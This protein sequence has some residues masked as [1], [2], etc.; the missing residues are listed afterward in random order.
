MC[1]RY[2]V[3]RAAPQPLRAVQQ[4][5]NSIDR[6]ARARLARRL[7]R[8]ARPGRRARARPSAARG[9]PLARAREQRPATRPRGRRDA[10][11]SGRATVAS[12]GRRR[13]HVR[14]DDGGD[15]LDHLVAVAL[16]CDAR[17]L[18]AAAEGLPQLPL[19]V[20][21]RLAEPLGDLVLDAALRQ[22]REDQDI[23]DAPESRVGSRACGRG[24]RSAGS[25]SRASAG[26]SL[27]NVGAVA[28]R[29]SAAY[30][31]G[32]AVVGLF[33]TALVLTHAAMQ[34]PA[35]KL[36]DRFGAAASSERPGSS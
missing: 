19:V 26:W 3:P 2:D 16:R 31:V 20:L 29:T 36:C 8:R 23:P 24:R 21:R 14:F 28:E 11:R 25:P 4:F 13:R 10:E 17:R 33:T 5:V 9:V 35:G 18:V 6:R 34:I 15:P 30:G 7:V 12:P 1:P 27:A 22:P 32:L